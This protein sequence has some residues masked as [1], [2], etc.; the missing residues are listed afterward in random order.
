MRGPLAKVRILDLSRMLSGPFGS[1]VLAD[2]G[3][4][5]IKIEEPEGGDKTRTM[6]P[7]L[8]EGQ[9]AYFLSINRNKKSLALDLRK[10]K[11][12]EIF[13]ELVKLSDVVF[14]NFRPGVLE[15][16]GCDYET[17]KRFNPKIISCSISSFGHTGPDKD[18]PGFDLILQARAGAM[19][20]TGEPGRPPVR[21]G[22]PTG[23][24]A[25]AM[26]AAL[27]V[28]AALY[29]REKTGVGQKIDISLLDCQAA[30]LTYVAQYYILNGRVPGPIGSGH[31]TVVPYQAFQ[32]KDEYIAIAIFVEKFWEKLCRVLGLAPLVEDAKFCTNDLRRENKAELLPILE[33]KFLEKTAAEW[34][35]LLADEGIPSAPVNTVDKVLSDPQLLSRNMLVEADHPA[36]G[37]VRVLGNPMKMSEIEEQAF[38]AA[39]TLGEHTEEIL[40]ELLGYS[41]AQIE[42]LRKENLI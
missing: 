7:K 19:S 32:T 30:F 27:A 6:G 11:G 5:V 41:E 13:Y 12:R 24:L 22:I 17:L 14:D 36:Y 38:A 16:L 20:I 25:G 3:A 40:S 26:Y 34:L 33:K 29:S 9:S 31:Q 8:S 10:E 37:K 2:L 4:E 28:V 23:D 18:L 15:R 21:M 42:K 1:M 39:P 35:N